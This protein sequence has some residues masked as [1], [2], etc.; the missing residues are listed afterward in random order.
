MQRSLYNPASTTASNCRCTVGGDQGELQLPLLDL[1]V[2]LLLLKHVSLY[3]LLTSAFLVLCSTEG[4]HTVA[5]LDS[6]SNQAPP[7]Y[8]S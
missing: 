6:E 2:S 7:E 5:L 1:F 4:H 8:S 3:S